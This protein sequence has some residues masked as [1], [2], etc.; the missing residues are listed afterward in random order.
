MDIV[1]NN[2]NTNIYINSNN[3][4]HVSLTNN[5]AYWLKL[6]N[7]YIN[8]ENKS[9]I[10]KYRKIL[11]Q[12]DINTIIKCTKYNIN[13][14]PI[15]YKL[16]Y[17]D[18]NLLINEALRCVNIYMIILIDNYVKIN[19]KLIIEQILIYCN[20]INVVKYLHQ[21]IKLIKQDFQLDDNRVYIW[22]Y[23]NGHIE[24]VM[25]MLLNIYI[26]KLN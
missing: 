22:S 4:R 3:K 26:K 10:G 24:M 11:N 14:V 16:K 2:V 15:M 17:D 23:R 8:K 12:K 5:I 13:I 1:D 7:K 9:N 21:K 20:N 19:R 18:I 6:D 25:L